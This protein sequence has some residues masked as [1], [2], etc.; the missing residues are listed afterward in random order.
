MDIPGVVTRGGGPRGLA[1]ALLLALLPSVS[2][3]EPPPPPIIDMHLHALPVDFPIFGGPPPHTVCAPYTSFPVWDQR[4]SYGEQFASHGAHPGCGVP[5]VS[6]TTDEVVMRETIGILDELNIIGVTSGPVELVERWKTASP[7]RIVPGLSF[8]LDE[9]APSPETLR[10]WHAEGRVAVFGEVAIQYQGIE[11]DDPRFEPY[12]AMAEEVG[13]PVGIH[14]GTGPP[15]APYLGFEHYRARMHSPLS[16][17]EPLRRHPR[18]QLYV[19]HAGWPMLDDTLALLY[20]HPQ[21]YVEVGVINYILPRAEFHRYLRR[22]VEAGFGHRILFGSDQ[23]I[24][25]ETIRIAV[26]SIESAEFLS[27]AQKRD[28]FYRNAARFLR[29]SDEEIAAHHGR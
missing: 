21:V 2:V 14:V 16:L 9:D 28:I 3:A 13:L 11:P 18:L 29:L 20:A 10:R 4:G 25:P 17:E 26:D 1:L 8:F 7:G 24:W 27:E 15:G 19:M 22:L 12:L 23:M 6:P 5:V